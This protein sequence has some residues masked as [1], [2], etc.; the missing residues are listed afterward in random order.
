MGLGLRFIASGM[1]TVTLSD[2]TN[3]ILTA[4]KPG[5]KADAEEVVDRGKVF[6]LGGLANIKTT[7]T[8]LNLLFRQA[9]VKA[10]EK[11]GPFVYIERET[12]D[13]TWW[14]SPLTNA[15]LLPE[16]ET[17]DWMLAAGKLEF[18]FTVS[19]GNYWEGPEASVGLSN[20]HGSGANGVLI[21]NHSDN[22]HDNHVQISAA[23]VTGDLPASTR[24]EMVNN[25]AERL[26]DIWIG[27][28]FTDPANFPHVLEAEN[29]TPGAGLTGDITNNAGASSGAYR[30]LGGIG[31]GVETNLL[32][33]TL[34]SALLNAAK[35]RYFRAMVR[36]MLPT[37]AAWE[38]EYQWRLNYHAAN[39]W[40][41]GYSKPEI[42]TGNGYILGLGILQLP[43]WL[44]DLTGLDE[45]TLSLWGRHTLG[46][47]AGI[48]PDYFM[49]VP[50]DGWRELRAKGYGV[51]TGARV[52]DDGF[53]EQLY[54]DN[55][56]GA[57]KVGLYIGLGKQI[58]L[59]PNK[60][61]RLYF[62]QNTT[63]GASNSID[64]TLTVKVYC[65]PRR[66]TL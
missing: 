64:Q 22:G 31:S 21:Y 48:N 15:L 3:T 34:S 46:S 62:L 39:I 24:I 65:R 44:P 5:A 37:S 49:L 28:N 6:F 57:G 8:N 10:N 61:Q 29:G 11:R 41:S 9:V 54:R 66:L 1:T 33:W 16:D 58:R 55:G 30:T 35:G 40:Q 56:A 42:R 7:I 50:I 38:M 14:R 32:S 17:L 18:D 60:L 13:G 63:S 59:E 53:E 25:F 23:S 12:G 36:L 2:G 4:Y 52:V 45:L 51:E 26:N 27:Q 20:R 19:R 43:P 47:P